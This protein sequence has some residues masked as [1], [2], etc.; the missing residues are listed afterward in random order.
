MAKMKFDPETP[1]YTSDAKAWR[2]DQLAAVLQPLTSGGKPLVLFV[3]GRGKEPGKSLLG[4]SFTQG[5]AVHKIERGYGVNVLMFNWDSAFKGFN[6]FDREEPLSHTAAGGAVLGQVLAG[7]QQF[8]SNYPGA[9]RPALLVH[10]MGSIVVERALRDNHWPQANG[11]FSAVL[12]SQ[13]DA[14]DVGHATWLD[15]LAQ[16]ERSFVT[17][18]RDDRVLANSTDGRPAG[19]Q[20][21]G[22]G[23]A[24]PLAPHARYI[25][26]SRM[27]PLGQKDDDHE[28]FGKGAMNGELNV[29]Q[30]FTQALTGQP[31]LLDPAVNVEAIEREVVY[32]LRSRREPGA[33]CLKLPQLPQFD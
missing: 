10:S 1:L 14:D 9:M 29:C 21:L 23:T 16:R 5:L 20:P 2:M 4:G 30:F 18:N 28:V 32:R 11:L 13:P 8:Q 19:A 22:L 6:V 33:P 27:G 3:H 17:W 24:Q 25:D 7:L 31:V 15:A 12:L 26:L